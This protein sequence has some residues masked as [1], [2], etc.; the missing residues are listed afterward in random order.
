[1]SRGQ[2]DKGAKRRLVE[3]PAVHVY[4]RYGVSWGVTINHTGPHRP[5]PDSTGQQGAWLRLRYCRKTHFKCCRSTYKHVLDEDFI[6]TR[7]E[8]L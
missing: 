2:T 1:M 6:L 7:C 5:T 8:K 4:S 3:L